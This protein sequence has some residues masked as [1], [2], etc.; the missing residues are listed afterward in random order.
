MHLF[1]SI[2][3]QGRETPKS[4]TPFELLEVG[5]EMGFPGQEGLPACELV[6]LSAACFGLALATVASSASVG[7]FPGR[8]CLRS[9]WKLLVHWVQSGDDMLQLSGWRGGT[10]NNLGSLTLVILV[11]S[12]FAVED[13]TFQLKGTSW[14]HPIP[15]SCYSMWSSYY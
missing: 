10:Q 11:S 4:Q 7:D 9:G 3:S 13:A 1:P 15:S 8:H 14:H 2:S 6:L 5:D 12:C